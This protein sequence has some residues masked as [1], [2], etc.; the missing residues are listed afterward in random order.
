MVMD[1]VLPDIG[2]QVESG[3]VVAVLVAAGDTVAKDDGIV[4]VETDK[5]VVEIPSPAD[6]TIVEILVKEG[7][8]LRIGDVVARLDRGDSSSG[9]DKPEEEAPPKQAAEEPA[10]E[11]PVAGGLASAPAKKDPKAA[12]LPDEAAV[13]PEARQTGPPPSDTMPVPAA[14]SVRRLA[15]ELGIDIRRVNGSG[16]G[17]RI[18]E[19]DVKDF[20]KSMAS[21]GMGGDVLARDAATAKALPDFT[22]FGSVRT[23][24]MSTVR[25]LTSESMSLAWR[26]MP[27]VTQFDSADVTHI[28]EWLATVNKKAGPSGGKVTIT[29]VLL[30]VIAESLRKF[31]RFNAS[32][33][34]QERLIHLKEYIHIGLAVDTER[35]LLVPVIRDVDKKTVHDIAR[36]M[37][38]LVDRTRN[39]RVQPDELEGGT[40]TLSNQGAIGGSNFTPIIYWPQAAILG[41][42]RAALEPV[43][44]NGQWE[45]RSR[46]PLSLSYD[47]RLN[48]GADAA[49]FL[50][51][52][53]N[54]LEYPAA[55]L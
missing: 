19:K 40:F 39:K 5:A 48:D 25:R 20:V 43:Y 11:E 24:D 12:S 38:D 6:G 44:R 9:G 14:P 31:P 52:I 50:R 22:R 46:L 8:T 34:V 42:S 30:R 16:P 3:T 15:R 21:A 45:P 47:H 2:E 13:R 18:S 1:I 27:H 7:D 29:A 49:R 53:C 35:G 10:D 26:T 33:D 41:V 17:G 4:E 28:L 32:L 54:A 23:E 55:L 37:N 36:E 51:W